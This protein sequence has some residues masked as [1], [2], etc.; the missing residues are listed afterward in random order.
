[1]MVAIAVFLAVLAA[2]ETPRVQDA[3]LGVRVGSTAA[4][5]QTT[6]GP[7]GTPETRPTRD[8]GNKQVWTLDGTPFSSLALKT[9]AAGRV[10]WVT[11]FV[12]AGQE[13]PFKAFGDLARAR[14]SSPSRVMWDVPTARGGYRLIARG[15]GRN[16]QTVSLLSFDAETEK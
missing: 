13:I 2:P 16:A 11:G 12:R 9:D 8:G 14:S 7:R 3:I 1:M 6:L 4:E 15:S 10:V 5:V